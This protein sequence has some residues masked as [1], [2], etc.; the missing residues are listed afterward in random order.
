MKQLTLLLVLVL[1]PLSLFA[2]K[3]L[4]ETPSILSYEN[5][6]FAPQP[7]V[8]TSEVTRERINQVVRELTIAR[9][10]GDAVLAE[11]LNSELEALSGNQS[12]KSTN[13]VNGPTVTSIAVNEPV[14][15]VDYNLTIINSTDGFWSLANSTD[16]VTGRIWAVGTKYNGTGSDTIKIFSSTDEG[17]TWVLVTRIQFSIAGVHYR[18]DELD[19]E[20]VNNGTTSYL[21]CVAGLNYGTSSYSLFVRTNVTGS[22]FYSAYLGTS[23]ATVKNIYPRITSDNSRYT[24]LS[25]VY[26]LWTQDSTRATD[27]VLKSMYALI[28]SPFAASPTITYRNFTSVGSYWWQTPVDT[29][30]DTTFQYNDIAYSDSLANPRIVTVTNVYRGTPMN[31]FLTYSSDYGATTPTWVPQ[32]TETKFSKKPIIAAT[33]LDSTTMMIVSTRQYSATDWDPYYYRTVNNG[34]NWSTGYISALSDTTL[35][36]DVVAIPRVPNTFR[37]AYSVRS[38]LDNSGNIFLRTYTKGSFAA[39]FQLNP[40]GFLMSG[41][42]TP[43]RAGYRYSSDS[44]FNL[45]SSVNGTGMYAFSGCSGAITGVGNS[46][47]PI[48]F[49]LSQNYPNPFNPTTKISYSIQRSGFVTLKVFDI[50]GREAAILV[51]EVKNAGNYS[52][53]FNASGLTSGIYFYKIEANGF[54]DVKKMMLLK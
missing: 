46:E 25:Y 14:E 16:R 2:Q 38:G 4:N 49:N 32:I 33:G 29:G 53:D 47:T 34:A 42:Y 9:T 44:C 54:S 6:S 39:I 28:L 5:T 27:R 8:Q 24:N 17:T 10:N 21:F 41:N 3:N 50:L 1:L 52:V 37:I 51:N 11:Q 18:A 15:E 26:F 23:S 22:E 35:S 30:N 31:L 36:T 45:A 12:F 43:V 7:L 20:A 13:S 19:V 40:A 48:S